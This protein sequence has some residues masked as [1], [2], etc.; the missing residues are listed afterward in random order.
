MHGLVTI[1][2]VYPFSET[3]ARLEAAIDDRGVRLFEKIDHAA[4]AREAG[5]TLRPTTAY[6]FGNPA[7]GTPLMERMPTLGLDLPLRVLV[8]GAHPDCY[9][10]YWPLLALVEN[11]HGDIRPIREAIAQIEELVADLVSE[12]VGEPLT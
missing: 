1:S 11:H 8:Y 12:A 7:A 2:S 10:C 4:L 5:L 3:C 6:A 9:V